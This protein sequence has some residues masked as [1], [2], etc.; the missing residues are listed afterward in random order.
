M[1]R[2][3]RIRR[4]DVHVIGLHGGSRGGDRHGHRGF[5]CQYFGKQAFVCRVQVLNHDEGHTGCWKGTEKLH[6]RFE[7]SGRRANSHDKGGRAASG[8]WHSLSIRLPRRKRP[9]S[10]SSPVDT[11]IGRLMNSRRLS[12]PG[13][14]L[15]RRWAAKTR[16]RCPCRARFRR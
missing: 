9:G 13:L 6:D 3:E 16:R 15:P 14:Q 7:A 8:F 11:Q 12:P 1:H 5:L 4:D 10:F 2:E